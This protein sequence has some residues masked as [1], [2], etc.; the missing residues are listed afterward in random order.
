VE[1]AMLSAD[2][3]EFVKRRKFLAKVWA[4]QDGIN[5]GRLN[6]QAQRQLHRF[7]RPTS[8]MSDDEAL[9]FRDLELR[10]YPGEAKTA[11]EVYRRFRLILKGKLP[12]D[13]FSMQ[14][15][16][17]PQ[18]KTRVLTARV[19]TN[20]LFNVDALLQLLV[21]QI[22][23]QQAGELESTQADNSDT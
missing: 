3:R 23:S 15:E 2:D 1:F 20:P 4:E 17:G 6:P 16:H 12:D 5:F 21:D 8:W 18:R 19:V 11:D 14:F 22:W 7:Y 10:D 13:E 9:D